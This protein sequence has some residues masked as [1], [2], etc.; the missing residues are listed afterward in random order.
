MK[1]NYHLAVCVL[2]SLLIVSCAVTNTD[3]SFVR[4]DSDI[5]LNEQDESYVYWADGNQVYRCLKDN[6]EVHVIGSADSRYL[7]FMLTIQNRSTD[8]FSIYPYNSRLIQNK[9]K[10]QFYPVRPREVRRD[11]AQTKTGLGLLY[12]INM[13]AIQLSPEGNNNQAYKDI[14]SRML[15]ND[16]AK[17]ELDAIRYTQSIVDIML[18]DH[19]IKQDEIYSG[20]VLFS[21]ESDFMDGFN[22]DKPF[23][24]SLE[25]AGSRVLIRG[26][27]CEPHKNDELDTPEDLKKIEFSL[28]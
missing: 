15:T 3:Y 1:L 25:I 23:I 10:D 5:V 17:T 11:L 24:L 28:K 18:K 13:V 26:K 21:I 4:W 12:S 20:C 16:Y 6:Y 9:G 22:P 7:Y 2:V 8:I 27:L 19:T 14:K